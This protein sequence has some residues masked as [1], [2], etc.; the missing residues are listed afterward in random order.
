MNHPTGCINPTHNSGQA[1]FLTIN[2]R[3]YYKV[4][5]TKLK[6]QLCVSYGRQNFLVNCVMCKR[7]IQIII[8]R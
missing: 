3:L 4:K 2:S 8:V 7:S 1:C 5:P 6:L